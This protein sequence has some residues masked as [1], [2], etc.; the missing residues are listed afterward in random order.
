ML[1]NGESNRQPLRTARGDFLFRLPIRGK[2]FGGQTI[3]NIILSALWQYDPA[4]ARQ[5]TD[6]NES[7]WAR[8]RKSHAAQKAG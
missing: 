2:N 5:Q 3:E 6:K 7:Q 8:P 1:Q 4:L